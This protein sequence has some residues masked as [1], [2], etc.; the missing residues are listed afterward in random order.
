MVSSATER[1]PRR[2]TCGTGVLRAD[3]KVTPGDHGM[4]NIYVQSTSVNR[5]LVGGTKVLYYKG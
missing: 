4:F 3:V 5:K 1:K 2:C